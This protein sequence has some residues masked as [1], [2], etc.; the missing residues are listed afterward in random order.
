M[1]GRRL[2]RLGKPWSLSEKVTFAVV[3]VL[4]VVGVALLVRWDLRRECVRWT[5][6]VESTGT[7]V[8]QT[9]VCAEYR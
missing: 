4:L 5:T 7:D 6:R 2:R 9:A 8:Y 3:I 1:E